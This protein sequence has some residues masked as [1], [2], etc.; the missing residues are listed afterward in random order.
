MKRIKTIEAINTFLAQF[1][2]SYII[3]DIRKLININEKHQTSYPYLAL[4]FSG[5][6]FFG[7]LEKGVKEKVRV[8]FTWFISEWMG[9]I[10]PLYRK[11]YLSNLIYNS[12]RNGI[13]HNAVLK[14]SFN[15]SSYLYPKSAHL[16]FLNKSNLVFLHSIQFA[17]DFLKAQE[18]YRKHILQSNDNAYIQR[19]G[20]NLSEMIQMNSSEN[21]S[22][23][24]QLISELRLQRRVLLEDRY[25]QDFNTKTTLST[26]TTSGPFTTTM[27]VPATDEDES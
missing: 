17:E 15:V 13:F 18:R 4:A 12:G 11:K 14:N 16:H 22:F 6:D 8:R 20:N 21:A 24:R 19:L 27:T 23:T 2:D 1:I 10:T 26:T 25:A 3:C 7:T 5:I 9:M